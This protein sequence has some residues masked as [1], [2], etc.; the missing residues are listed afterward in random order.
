MCKDWLGSSGSGDSFLNM[1]ESLMRNLLRSVQM[2][3]NAEKPSVQ[4]EEIP[5]EQRGSGGIDGQKRR[6]K[7]QVQEDNRHARFKL[8]VNILLQQK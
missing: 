3:E 8:I 4:Q 1:Y 5:A 6:K 7:R 2:M